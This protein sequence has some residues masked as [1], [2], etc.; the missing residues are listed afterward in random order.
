MKEEKV[1]KHPKKPTKKNNNKF[2]LFTLNTAKIPKNKED[3]TLTISVL[4]K[5][6]SDSV[7]KVDFMKNLKINPK[8]LPTKT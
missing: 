7:L 2:W 4:L 8:V 1:L 3:K 6:N 5:E